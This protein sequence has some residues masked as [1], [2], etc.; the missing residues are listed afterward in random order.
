ME[1]D[2]TQTDSSESQPAASSLEDRI[3]TPAPRSF[4]TAKFAIVICVLLGSV[5]GVLLAKNRLASQTTLGTGESIQSA[6]TSASDIKVGQTFGSADESTFRDSAEGV[7]VRG[8][9]DGEGSHHLERPGGPSQNVYLTSSIVDLDLFVGHRIMVWGETFAAKKAGWLM[10]A[11]RVKVLELN[12]DTPQ[13][14]TSG[15]EE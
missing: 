13:D 11:G 6:P 3:M 2:G 1:K 10:D 5:T 7:L 9:A 12:A 14:P 8:G 15:Q 4:P